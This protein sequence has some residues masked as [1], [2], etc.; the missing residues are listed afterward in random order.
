MLVLHVGVVM[1]MVDQIKIEFTRHA[2]NM[3]ITFLLLAMTMALVRICDQESRTA[4]R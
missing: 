2:L 1:F 4:E 3:H